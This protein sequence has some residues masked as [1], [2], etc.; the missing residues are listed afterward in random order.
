MRDSIYIWLGSCSYYKP[1]SQIRSGRTQRDKL[2]LFF[3]PYTD[4]QFISKLLIITYDALHF[5]SKH[6]LLYLPPRLLKLSE[7]CFLLLQG[8]VS[9]IQEWIFSGIAP[10]LWKALPLELWGM[11]LF[12]AFNRPTHCT[13]SYIPLISDFNSVLAINLFY[14]SVPNTILTV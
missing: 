10:D 12:K 13:F 7:I 3:K 5:V 4:C 1:G 6:L 8:Y 2:H 11:T 14:L 9:A